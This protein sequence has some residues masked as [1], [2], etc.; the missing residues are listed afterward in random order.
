MAR[1]YWQGTSEEEAF[2]PLSV[3]GYRVL[4]WPGLALAPHI[5]FQPSAGCVAHSRT[6]YPIDTSTYTAFLSRLP[7]VHATPRSNIGCTC[8][9]FVCACFSAAKFFAATMS[10]G[11]RIDCRLRTW[12]LVELFVISFRVCLVDIF[13]VITSMQMRRIVEDRYNTMSLYILFHFMFHGYETFFFFP[14]NIVDNMKFNTQGYGFNSSIYINVTL[15]IM[16]CK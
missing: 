7:C 8:F 5:R 14:N 10:K 1:L 12:K 11:F 6:F 16:I 13:F 3:H 2:P 9:P 4:P 15:N